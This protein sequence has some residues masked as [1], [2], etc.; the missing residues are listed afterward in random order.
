MLGGLATLATFALVDALVRRSMAAWRAFVFV[1]LTGLTCLML[2]GLSQHLLGDVSPRLVHTLQNSLGL[3]CAALS[4]NY[5]GL[6]LGVATEDRIV[7]LSISL[8]ASALIV[9]ATAMAILTLA[10]PPQGWH[11]LLL[12]TAI[13]N[14][15][16]IILP[17][18]A[19]I[20]AVNLGDRLAKGVLV[21]NVFL[22]CMTAGL[23][24][25]SL[26]VELGTAAY[27][28][29]A[30][31]TV[32]SIMLG[33]YLG[34]RRDRINRHL[35]RMAGI[36]QGDDPATGLPQA[37]VLLS[38]VDD[39]FWRSARRNLQCTVICLHVAN[40]YELAESAGHN[41]DKQI[42][43]ALSARLRRAVGFRN[44]VG[45]YHPRCFVVVIS[46]DSKTRLVENALQRLQYLTAKPLH[47]VGTNFASH[48]F[49]PRFGI[50]SVSVTPD[51]A[52]AARV[53]DQ[54]ER[55]ALAQSHDPA[56]DS[57][58]GNSQLDT[59]IQQ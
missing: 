20:R 15:A 49:V 29:T 43:S 7:G 14:G 3:L 30:I 32:G 45:L 4:L 57:A 24:T 10:S 46:T 28:L 11:D 16:A 22:A 36:A 33:T 41:A 8:G 51:N 2:T 59:T 55:L 31:S 54:A 6:W 53:I 37:S 25:R 26:D 13:I 40:L 18:I 27:I 52:D 50:G 23:Y 34:L 19:A 44:V 12:V 47:V 38:K 9:A 48:V 5:L 42:L 39:A 35:K 17:T 1:L 58:L 21:D 56:Q